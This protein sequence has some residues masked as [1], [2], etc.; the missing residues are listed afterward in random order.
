MKLELMNMKKIFL[1]FVI[2][3]CL[4]SFSS[5]YEPSPLYGT[6]SDNNGNVLSFMTDGSFVATLYDDKNKQ[7]TFEGNFDLIDNVI[8]FSYKDS[9]TGSQGVLN[10]EW[11]LRGSIL[12]CTW[13]MD[14]KT[15]LMILYHTAR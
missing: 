10:S 5:C 11:D 8:V 3:L 7:K 4:L 12:Y 14:K 2:F 13:T 1:T 9:E 6:W 15:N